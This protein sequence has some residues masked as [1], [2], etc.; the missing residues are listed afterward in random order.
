MDFF[1]ALRNLL[2]G[3]QR[4]APVQR[5]MQEDDAPVLTQQGRMPLSS[6]E[7][8]QQWQNPETGYSPTGFKA[9]GSVPVFGAQNVQNR[10]R[11]NKSFYSFDDLPK[12]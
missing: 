9:S 1:E 2:G 8:G 10:L 12:F 6:V 7:R 11:Q 3:Q 4:P 5:R